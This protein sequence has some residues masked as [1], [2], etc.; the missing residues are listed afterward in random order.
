MRLDVISKH[1]TVLELDDKNTDGEAIHFNNLYSTDEEITSFA[2]LALDADT[3]EHMGSPETITISVESGDRLN[4][5]D[6]SRDLPQ[7]RVQDTIGGELV[8]GSMH[9]R[10]YTPEA[11]HQRTHGSVPRMP[12]I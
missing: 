7:M 11:S 9:P 5:V 2:L 3:W 6:P 8:E 1:T 12:H 10:G 4:V